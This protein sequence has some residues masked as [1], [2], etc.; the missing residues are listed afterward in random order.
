VLSAAAVMDVAATADT[1]T[2]RTAAIARSERGCRW[3][4]LLSD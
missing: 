4:W 3:W 1:R 2:A